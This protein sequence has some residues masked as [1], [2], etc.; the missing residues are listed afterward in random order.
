MATPFRARTDVFFFHCAP[1]RAAALHPDWWD[2]IVHA[3]ETNRFDLAI[4]I[5]ARRKET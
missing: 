1:S 2:I 3:R 4:R 5:G